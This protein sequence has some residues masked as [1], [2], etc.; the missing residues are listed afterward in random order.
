MGSFG[1]MPISSTKVHDLKK[2]IW[3][4]DALVKLKAYLIRPITC[5]ATICP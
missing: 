5:A 3:G 1:L 4:N 2:L